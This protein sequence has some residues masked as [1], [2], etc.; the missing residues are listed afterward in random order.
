VVGLGNPGPQY[1][2]SRH[3]IGWRVLD[4]V[5]R[6]GFRPVRGAPA[7]V[8]AGPAWGGESPILLAKPTTFMN[9]SGLAVAALVRRY[10]TAPA[11][12]LILLDDADLPLGRLRLRAAGSAGGHRGL[13]SV[14]AALGTEDV[15]RLRL[16]VGRPAGGRD[17]VEHVLE[18]FEAA[19]IEQVQAMARQGGEA[20]ALWAR[21]GIARAMS[22]V[23]AW[24]PSVS[25]EPSSDGG[26]EP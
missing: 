16:G 4:E 19:E 22:E 15:P 2:A 12:L 24:R 13:A 26:E 14:L 23:N 18:E 6:G 10:G 8:A 3:N 11:D 1:A 20:V 7:E 25:G 21:R 9:N 17:M 5:A